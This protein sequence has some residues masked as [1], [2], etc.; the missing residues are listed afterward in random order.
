MDLSKK[1]TV[2]ISD[3]SKRQHVSITLNGVA[4]CTT[5]FFMDNVVII[6]NLPDGRKKGWLD[7]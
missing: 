4:Y 1:P 6:P 2:W 7:R 5:V 3:F